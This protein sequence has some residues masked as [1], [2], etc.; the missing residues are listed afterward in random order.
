MS[1]VI[2]YIAMAMAIPVFARQVDPQCLVVGCS[3]TACVNKVEYE[4]SPLATTCA[5]EEWYEC[6]HSADCKMAHSKCNWVASSPFL[7]CL[8]QKNAPKETQ[9]R[10][11]KN[12]LGSKSEKST[13]KK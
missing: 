13:T 9:D 1:I 6:F 12:I 4:E 10:I 2:T 7:S 3:G 8:K 11:S 5:W